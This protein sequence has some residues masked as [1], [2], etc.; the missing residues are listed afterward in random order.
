MP[1]NE[2]HHSNMHG[3][4]LKWVY[5]CSEAWKPLETHTDIPDSRHLFNFNVEAKAKGSRERRQFLVLDNYGDEILPNRV[6]KRVLNM[7]MF[8]YNLVIDRKDGILYTAQF[9]QESSRYAMT[10]AR[11]DPRHPLKLPRKFLG[12]L[13]ELMSQKRPYYLS[14]WEPTVWAFVDREMGYQALRE[15]LL[16]DLNFNQQRVQVW[17]DSYRTVG[18]WLP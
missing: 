15:N 9:V 14:I 17:G 16:V 3:K 5:L 4:T 7:G 12:R 2:I 6:L 8:Q 10:L 1:V 18:G 13:N 11:L